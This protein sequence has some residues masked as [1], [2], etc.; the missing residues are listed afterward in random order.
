MCV[1]CIGTPSNLDWIKTPDAKR[2][3]SAIGCKQ[4]QSFKALFPSASD[5]SRALIKAMLCMDPKKRLSAQEAHAHPWFKC[6]HIA[7]LNK[8]N[9]GR[10]M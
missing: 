7:N 9:D 5:E 10:V 6:P 4:G 3:V 1:L 2:W 8:K